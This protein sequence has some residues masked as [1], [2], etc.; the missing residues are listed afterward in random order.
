MSVLPINER[1]QDLLVDR[2]LHGLTPAQARELS[3]L[4]PETGADA[5]ERTAAAIDL[6]CFGVSASVP[7]GLRDRLYR[8]ADDFVRDRGQPP[9]SVPIARR[10]SGFNATRAAWVALAASVA[11][12]GF[13]WLWLPNNPSPRAISPEALLVR[14][15]TVRAPWA[16]WDG[17]EIAGVSGE[18]VWCEKAQSGFMRLKGL[19]KNEPGKAQYQLWIIDRRGLQDS[20]GQSARISGG[21]FDSDAGEIVVPITPAIP[22]QGA[23]AFAITIEDPGGTWVSSMKRRVAIAKLSPKG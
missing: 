7:Q 18:V 4:G 21:V 8:A 22:V 12:A 3:E 13:A 5:F 1:L 23:A 10:T 11:L 20:A 17:P 14:Q 19:P 15:D 16:D 2:A 9:V 6:F